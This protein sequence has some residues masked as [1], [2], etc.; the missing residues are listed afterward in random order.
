MIK[1]SRLSKRPTYIN[2]HLIQVLHD[3]RFIYIADLLSLS[4]AAMIF[5]RITLKM[6]IIIYWHNIVIALTWNFPFQSVCISAIICWLIS[7][8]S[9]S[10]NSQAWIQIDCNACSR[11]MEM[12]RVTSWCNARWNIRG[13]RTPQ[14]PMSQRL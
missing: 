12:Y 9:E 3:I 7:F 1:S 14:K 10:N 11:W 4:L 13:W 8:L 2:K 6:R 5:N